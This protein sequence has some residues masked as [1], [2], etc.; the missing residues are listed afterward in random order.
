[1]DLSKLV[2]L[3]QYVAIGECHEWTGPY[4]KV[5]RASTHTPRVRRRVD[6]KDRYINIPRLIWEKAHGPVRDGYIVYRTCC[7]H[8]CVKLQHLA[9][10]PL[11]Q[12][13]KKYGQAGKLKKSLMA[14]IKQV[15]KTREK[16]NCTPEL[17]AKIREIRAAGGTRKEAEQA[18]G[19]G[20]E[21]VKNIWYGSRWSQPTDQAS[22]TVFSFAAR[23]LIAPTPAKP[24]ERKRHADPAR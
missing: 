14:W 21:Q 16:S 3:S 6:G 8:R 24:A 2:D 1:M 23:S 5:G 7:N 11:G 18:T 22:A 15:A 19:L 4:A 12:H 13:L 17:A 9:A 20:K 10:A